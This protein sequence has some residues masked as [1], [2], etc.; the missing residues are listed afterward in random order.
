MKMFIVDEIEA[1]SDLRFV[2]RDDSGQRM[3]IVEI[4]REKHPFFVGVQFHP[5]FTVSLFS[6]IIFC[7]I[8]NFG[9]KNLF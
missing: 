6:L 1:K 9:K 2:G 7:I 3:E 8:F 5:E 4:S